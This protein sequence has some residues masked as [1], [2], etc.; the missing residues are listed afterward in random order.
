MTPTR[1]N[2]HDLSNRLNINSSKDA[3]NVTLDEIENELLNPAVPKDVRMSK[4]KNPT[5][6]PV[7]HFAP[8]QNKTPLYEVHNLDVKAF[9][10]IFLNGKCGLENERHIPLSTSDFAKVTL[11][12]VDHRFK[13]PDW[14]FFRNTETILLQ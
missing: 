10:V 12:N 13:R 1:L 8:G 3:E 9:P 7:Y 2:V 11:K 14:T 5:R 4:T 6:I